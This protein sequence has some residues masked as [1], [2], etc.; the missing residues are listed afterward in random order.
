MDLILFVLQAE[1]GIICIHTHYTQTLK[2]FDCTLKAIQV[3]AN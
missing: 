2:Y 3:N 1:V